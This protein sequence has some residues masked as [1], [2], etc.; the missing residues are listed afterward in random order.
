MIGRNQTLAAFPWDFL[1]LWHVD[2]DPGSSGKMGLSSAYLSQV[3]I[4][5]AVQVLLETT[6]VN[7]VLVP[8]GIEV[9]MV[10]PEQSMAAWAAPKGTTI[11]ASTRQGSYCHYAQGSQASCLVPKTVSP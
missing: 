8:V 10:R 1:P 4:R 3:S 9:R 11:D 2:M 7:C 6:D 5:E